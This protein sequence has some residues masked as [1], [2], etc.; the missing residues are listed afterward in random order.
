MGSAAGFRG[1]DRESFSSNEEPPEIASHATHQATALSAR[2][3][4]SGA[5][6]QRLRQ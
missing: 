4:A 1:V 5:A 2:R 3:S 6:I